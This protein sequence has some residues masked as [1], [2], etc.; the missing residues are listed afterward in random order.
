MC[1]LFCWCIVA[2]AN[3]EEF[4][5]KKKEWQEEL[6]DMSEFLLLKSTEE[7]KEEGVEHPVDTAF[8]GNSCP[9]IL[10]YDALKR[11]VSCSL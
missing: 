1:F 5:R 9:S 10:H 11:I 7:Q 6:D 8:I 4:E 3:E 2:Q